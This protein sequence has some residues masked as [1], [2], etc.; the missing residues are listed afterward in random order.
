MWLEPKN[1]LNVYKEE[2]TAYGAQMSFE[3]GVERPLSSLSLYGHST[4]VTTTGVQLLKPEIDKEVSNFGIDVTINNG[5]A[6]FK[7]TRNEERPEV[8]P[9]LAISIKQEVKE[10]KTIYAKS[11]NTDII[12]DFH[13]VTSSGE[14]LYNHQKY[15]VVGD[16]KEINFRVLYGKKPVPSG[17]KIDATAKVMVTYDESAEWEPYTGGKPS[18][19]PEYPQPINNVGGSN[20]LFPILEENLRSADGLK[21]VINQDGSITVT[22]T[23]TKQY[24]NLYR[25]TLN[26]PNGEYYISGGTINTG[27]MNFQINITYQD[28]TKEYWNNRS[29]NVDSNVKKMEGIIQY[30]SADLQPVNYTIYPILNK[31]DKP[32]PFEKYIDSIEVNSN[33]GNLFPI[34]EENL[35]RGGSLKGVI[36][37]D[38]SVTVTGTPK[39]RYALAL[40]AKLNLS[41]GKYCI[42]GG[43]QNA[44]EVSTQVRFKRKGVREYYHGWSENRKTFTIDE[45]VTD[46]EALIYYESADLQP[47][48]YTIYPMLNVGD[49]PLP[50]EPYKPKQT[51]SLKTPNGLPGIPLSDDNTDVTPTYIDKNG[52]KWVCDEI[53]L[54]RG[55]YVQRVK[56]IN[57]ADYDNW[58]LGNTTDPIRFK[59]NIENTINERKRF[60]ILSNRFIFGSDGVHRAGVSFT[61]SN[62]LYFYLPSTVTTV[63]QVKQWFIDNPTTSIYILGEPVERDLTPEEIASYK[64]I[65]TYRPTTVISS[66]AWMQVGYYTAYMETKTNWKS[67]D[68]FNVQDYNRIKRNL[69][70]IR[71][72]ALTLWPDFTFEEMGEDKSYEDYSFYA[73]EINRFEAN[74]EHICQ[75]TFPFQVGE[76]QTF[77]DNTPFIGWKELNRLEEACR[78]MYSNIKSRDNGRKMLP[79]TL[80]GGV[81]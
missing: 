72:L 40:L 71:W 44:G 74:V 38:G 26:L 11:D 69:N 39:I 41:N 59:I 16:E 66:D 10:N 81:L 58:I 68:F 36:N 2:N 70:D 45:N 65:K 29:F 49:K 48:N 15:T 1:D 31:G 7:G 75:G 50:F 23:P 55:K 32:L 80:N 30:S 62:E 33:G 76:R 4:Q 5:I 19:S 73:D 8:R 78:L 47:V 46:I 21:G 28:G 20:N 13:I 27:E 14:S 35:T 3:T 22:G 6:S 67:S 52:K 17:T 43:T 25:I 63:E 51:L 56:E 60:E 37:S 61:Y 34:L 57:P 18:P 9:S 12:V 79:F 64:S 77:Y 53:D 42:N 54:G 24:A